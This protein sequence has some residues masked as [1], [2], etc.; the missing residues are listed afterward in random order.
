GWDSTRLPP[1][2][3]VSS[4]HPDRWHVGRARAHGYRLPARLLHQLPPLPAPVPH[5]GAGRDAQLTTCGGW[6][7]A[8]GVGAVL[9]DAG[10]TPAV[11]G[12]QSFLLAAGGSQG[13]LLA[14]MP[15]EL[16]P[17]G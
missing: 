14:S 7:W 3:G 8:V 11:G 12:S 2:P 4:C 5:H 10:L 15:P 17:D 16:H 6:S 13:F 1:W 9:A